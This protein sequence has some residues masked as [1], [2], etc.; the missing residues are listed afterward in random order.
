MADHLKNPKERYFGEV[1]CTGFFENYYFVGND[2]GF[3]RVFDLTERKKKDLK[4]LFDKHLQ[5]NKVMCIDL[6]QNME[7]LVAGYESGALA[8]FDMGAYKLVKIMSEAHDTEI[9]GAKIINVNL[10]KH[11][12]DIVS[13]EMVGAVVR[14]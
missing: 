4:P 8:L 6:S 10:E 11:V 14:T 2:K 1:S 5:D 3:I 7:Y 13:I 12:V 9:L